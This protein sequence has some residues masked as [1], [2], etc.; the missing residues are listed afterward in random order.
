MTELSVTRRVAVAGAAAGAGAVMSVKASAQQGASSGAP[1]TF[2][3]V[4]GAWHGGWCYQRVAR[5]LQGQGHIVYTPTLTG[6]ADRSHLVG[7]GV[8]LDTHVTDIANLLAWDDLKDVVLVGHSYG[9]MVITG[10][11]EKAGAGAIGSIVFLDAFIPEDGKSLVDYQPED[12][13]A[14]ML[15]AAAKNNGMVA[16]IPSAAFNVNEKD[17]AWVDAKCTPQPIATFTDTVRVTGA[18]DRI[19]RKSYIRAG[20]Y[21]SPS[22]DAAM[23]RVKG[24]DDWRVHS[25]PGGHDLMVDLPNELAALLLKVA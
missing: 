20:A 15:A 17:R 4:H 18:V 7:K 19:P 25:L 1:K 12:R 11:A 3:L 9:G 22:F 5:L 21:A 16:P 10:V 13:R 6:L 24:R 23:A 8:T 14:G 2:V